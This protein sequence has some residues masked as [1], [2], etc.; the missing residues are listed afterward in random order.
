MP[1]DRIGLA[2]DV[3][4]VL[5]AGRVM[6]F[7]SPATAGG[8]SIGRSDHIDV[9]GGMEGKVRELLELAR[10]GVRSEIFH[11]SRLGDFLDG[12]ATGGTVIKGGPDVG[13]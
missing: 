7:L 9:T 6:P 2:T 11:I 3:P 1:L 8:L 13:A 5:S 10:A 12:T 4:G